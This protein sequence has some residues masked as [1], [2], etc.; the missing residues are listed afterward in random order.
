MLRIM[1]VVRVAVVTSI[2]T[3]C[4]NAFFNY[5]FIYGNFGISPLG[6]KGAA[7][8][9]LIS[10]HVE[11]AILL[12]LVLK[13]KKK[14]PGLGLINLFKPNLTLLKDYFK[15]TLPVM[16]EGTMWGLSTG[17]QTVILGH[18]A[19]LAIAANSISINLA[20][21]FKVV[22][23]ASSASASV[24]IGKAVGEGAKNRV[25]EYT[26]T[27]QFI[28]I[29][30][31][32]FIF[33]G[34][35]ILREPILTLYNVSE[36]TK[37]LSRHFMLVLAFTSCGG[38]YQMPCLTGI[39]R[40][41][42]DTKFVMLNDLVSVWGIVLPVSALGAFVFHWSP[43]A[44]VISLNSDQIFK[45]FAAAIKVNSFNWMKQLTRDNNITAS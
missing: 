32:L 2:V 24:M 6:A 12:I 14:S 19:V 11:L 38:A 33:S 13:L 30:M 26:K 16:M 28:F 23:A 17:I 20:M 27:L 21:V 18:V 41:G 36:E 22:A 42:G 37:E 45:C 40:G 43:V 44:L 3:L 34:I 29:C 10:R 5:I 4:L 39:V 15:V 1:G 7:L 35:L 8:A 25:Y 9:T 31:G